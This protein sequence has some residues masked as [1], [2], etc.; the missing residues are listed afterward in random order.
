M[1]VDSTTIGSGLESARAQIAGGLTEA[2]CHSLVELIGQIRSAGTTIVWIE[3]VVHALLAS[4]ER[5]VC[6]AGG[7]LVADGDPHDVLNDANVRDLYLGHAVVLEQ[8]LR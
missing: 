1:A 8:D 7:R 6:L 2:E 3:H 4:V 5:L